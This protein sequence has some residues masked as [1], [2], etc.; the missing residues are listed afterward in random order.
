MAKL[1]NSMPHVAILLEST[2]ATHTQVLRGILRFTQLHTPW[3]LDV[4]MG[5]AGEPTSFDAEKWNVDGVIATR[6]PTELS[7]LIRRHRTPTIVMN[8][9]GREVRPIARILCDNAAIA[10]LAADMLAGVGFRDFAFV[11]ERSGIQWSVEREQAFVAEIARRGFPC[12]VYQADRDD[13]SED[14]RHLQEWLLGLPRPTALFAA[15]DIRARQVLDA[16]HA[17]GLA[18]PDDIAILGVDDDEVICETATPALS[19][20]PLSMEDAGFRAAELLDRVLATRRRPRGTTDII[21][22]GTRVVARRSTA[23]DAVAD[24]LVRRCRALMEANVGRPFNVADL[25]ASLGVSRRTL[26][27]RF[28]AATG[29]SLNAEITDMRIRR[30]KT[31]LAKSSMPQAAIATACGFCDASHLNVIFRRHCGAPPSAFRENK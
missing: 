19:S 23:R 29:R 8:D 30:A 27:T 14:N 31:M 21:F 17:A 2:Y 10:R 16:C 12:H 3:T 24:A 15:Y 6:L 7:T 1:A 5:R 11:G 18:V 9:I 22:T 4:R 26:E 28:R 20:I 25:V 13:A